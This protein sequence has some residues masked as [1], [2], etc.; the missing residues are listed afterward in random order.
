VHVIKR[1]SAIFLSL[2]L[3]LGFTLVTN[4][5]TDAR[6]SKN[7]SYKNCITLN[8]EFK[9]GVAKSRKTKNKGAKVKHQPFVSKTLYNKNKKNDRDKDGIA[10]ER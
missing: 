1:I 3:I 6:P 4:E 10:C 2:V 9:G 5:T 7:K 8:K